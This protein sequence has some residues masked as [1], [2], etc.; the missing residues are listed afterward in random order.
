MAVKSACIHTIYGM[1]QNSIEKEVWS[2]E[3]K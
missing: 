1:E 2:K 3:D